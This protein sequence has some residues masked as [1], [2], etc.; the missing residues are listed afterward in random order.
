MIWMSDEWKEYEVLDA[1]DGERL[2]RWGK[3]ILVRPD[4][5]VI[6]TAP[7][8]DPNWMPAISVPI[9][10]AATGLTIRCP[11]PGRSIIKI[12]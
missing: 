10:A 1:A 5:Q 7:H 9:P 12:I 3:Y 6:W 11:N 2:E 4:P 8:A